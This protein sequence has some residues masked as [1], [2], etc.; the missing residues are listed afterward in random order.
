VTEYK[1]TVCNSSLGPQGE[2]KKVKT[3]PQGNPSGPGDRLEDR[4]HGINQHFLQ[5]LNPVREFGV[6]VTTPEGQASTREKS[7]LL[8]YLRHHLQ[9]GLSLRLSYSGYLKTKTK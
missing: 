1:E 3:Q 7:L 2:K 6:I 9:R 5:A 8:L 4:G